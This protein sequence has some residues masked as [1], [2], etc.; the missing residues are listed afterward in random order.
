MALVLTRRKGESMLIG[1]NIEVTVI[2]INGGQVKIAI[3]APMDI[4]I[5]RDELVRERKEKCRL[6][7]S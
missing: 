4:N 2:S 3:D 1:D 7:S 6:G 5:V